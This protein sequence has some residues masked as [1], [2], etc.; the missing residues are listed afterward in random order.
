[1]ATYKSIYNSPM[2]TYKSTY[3]S[4]MMTYKSTLRFVGHMVTLPP[5]HTWSWSLREGLGAVLLCLVLNMLVHAFPLSPTAAF[6][7]LGIFHFVLSR[8]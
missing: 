8:C 4:P 2:T 5:D 6:F 1:M 3:N 7:L